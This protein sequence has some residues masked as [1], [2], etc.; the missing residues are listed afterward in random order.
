MPLTSSTV[1]SFFYGPV[2][3]AIVRRF[4]AKLPPSTVGIKKKFI[5]AA[6]VFLLMPKQPDRF[7]VCSL[8]HEGMISRALRK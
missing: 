2:A 7:S 8:R 4:L 5:T 3:L 6:I 1:Y